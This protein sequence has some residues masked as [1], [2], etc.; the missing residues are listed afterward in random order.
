MLE[1]NSIQSPVVHTHTQGAF[2][3]FNKKDRS[4][5]RRGRGADETSLKHILQLGLQFQLLGRGD[6][7]NPAVGNGGVGG[8]WDVVVDGAEGGN[9]CEAFG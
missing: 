9:A 6:G 8:E 2:L 4:T 7:I 3:L 5:I 1:R